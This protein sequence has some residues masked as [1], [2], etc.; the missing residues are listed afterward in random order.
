M[1][2]LSICQSIIGIVEKHADG[3][4]VRMVNLRIGA[5]RQIVPDTLMYCWSLITE[6]SAFEGAELSV[7]R[8]AARL[9]C[10]ACGHERTLDEPI[11]VCA[12][13]SGQQ[14][15]LVAGDEF[16]ITSLELAEV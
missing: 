15:T 10:D 3:R 9:R 4:G 5:M 16:L 2:E 13:C 12:Q 8:V 6:G 1:H 14:V 7:E 11:L